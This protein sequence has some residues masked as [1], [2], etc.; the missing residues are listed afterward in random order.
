M[1]REPKKLTV[2]ICFVDDDGKVIYNNPKQALSE[3]TK[4]EQYK[5]KA[6]ILRAVTGKTHKLI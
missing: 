6:R 4:A 3:M 2:T 5:L 1:E